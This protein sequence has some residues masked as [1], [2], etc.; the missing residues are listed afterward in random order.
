MSFLKL[1]DTFKDFDFNAYFSEVKTSD[2]KATLKRDNLGVYDLLNLLSDKALT[3]LEEIAR[4]SN[5]LTVNNFGRTINLYTPLYLSNYCNNEC[6]YCGFRKSNKIPRL[7]LDLAAV[8]EELR[9]I[10]ETGVKHILLLTGESH[11]KTPLS[12]L[13]D[14]VKI[15]KKYFSS[16]SI[17]IYPLDE[18]SYGKLTEAGVDGLTIYQ[19]VYDERV[20]EKVH[21]SGPKR[22]YKYRLDAPERAARAGFRNV[23]IGSL[24][25]LAEIRKEAFFAALHAGYLTDKYLES[26]ISL[27]LPRIR[28]ESSGFKPFYLLDNK[29]F[30]Q[31]M[32]AFRLFLPRAGITI[33]TRERAEF[34]NNLINL[35]ATRFSAGSRTT[36][37][38]HFLSKGDEMPQFEVSDERSVREVSALIKKRGYQ[39]VYKDWE[40]LF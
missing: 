8:E 26:E 37:G 40:T 3:L 36:V 27:S 29:S 32:L 18:E 5:R 14:A 38:G 23:N 1:K 15:S 4:A 35:G 21:I 33:S 11:S 2:I 16:V 30:V 19:E 28:Q 10:S 25:G 22:D 9:V 12:Y 24:F 39:V 31:I 20:Y 34:R 13:L 6:V 7:K 17:E